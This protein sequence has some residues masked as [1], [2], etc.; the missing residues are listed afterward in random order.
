MSFIFTDIDEE[1]IEDRIKKK[2]ISELKRTTYH[3]TPMK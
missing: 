1:L 2:V 3:W